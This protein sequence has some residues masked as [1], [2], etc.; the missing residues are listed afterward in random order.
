MANVSLAL[1]EPKLSPGI[2]R[3]RCPKCSEAH[4]IVVPL[5][6]GW[7]VTGGSTPDDVSISPSIWTEKDVEKPRCGLHVTV[8]GGVVTG[9]FEPPAT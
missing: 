8:S 3:F 7:N 2:L 1:L 6:G 9:N 5:G 4:F